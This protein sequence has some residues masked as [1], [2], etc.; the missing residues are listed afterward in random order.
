MNEYGIHA[1]AESLSK[2]VV[3]MYLRCEY[4]E[5]VEIIL[6]VGLKTGTEFKFK[7]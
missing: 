7:I 5:H 4:I 3:G 6:K 1:R 2:I